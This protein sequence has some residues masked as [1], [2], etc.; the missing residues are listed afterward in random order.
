M[1]RLDL[2][3]RCPR[4]DHDHGIAELTAGRTT[5]LDGR[6]EYEVAQAPERGGVSCRDLSR[7]TPIELVGQECRR[8]D[9]P[10]ALRIGR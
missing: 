10:V 5:P 6:S 8:V 7:P 1:A 4:A 9:R 3:G 2:H